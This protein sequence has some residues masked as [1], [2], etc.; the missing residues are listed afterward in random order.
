MYLVSHNRICFIVTDT[1]PRI[2]TMKGDMGSG[3]REQSAKAA[4]LQA[5]K[6]GDECHHTSTCGLTV[7]FKGFEAH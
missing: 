6:S 3:S 1:L 2:T 4:M 5:F 7:P